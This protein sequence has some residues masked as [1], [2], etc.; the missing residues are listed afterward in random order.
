MKTFREL[1]TEAVSPHNVEK[2]IRIGKDP[3]TQFLFTRTPRGVIGIE[4]GDKG[5][6]VFIFGNERRK[7]IELMQGKG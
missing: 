1:T 6:V 7:L 5:N 2:E 4:Y 3:K